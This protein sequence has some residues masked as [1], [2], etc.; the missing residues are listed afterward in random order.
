MSRFSQYIGYTDIIACFRVRQL[1]VVVL[2][3]VLGI[4]VIKLFSYLKCVISQPIVIKLRL[5]IAYNIVDFRSVSDFYRATL[6]LL[7]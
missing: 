6:I 3:V 4:V 1:R 2:V 7:N 5:Q